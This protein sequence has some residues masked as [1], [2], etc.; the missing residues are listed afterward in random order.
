MRMDPY[1]PPQH[2]LSKIYRTG[3]AIF[4]IGL[5]VF[6]ALGL[7]NRL[8]L[9]TTRGT[10]IAGLSSN[11]LLAWISIVV[12]LALLGA[13]LWGGAVASTTTAVIG[14]LFFLSGLGNLAVL[15]TSW[16]LLAFE[17]PNVVFSLIA[18]LLLMFLGFYG[19]L[20]GGLPEDNPY[21]R[22]RHREPPG[23]LPAQRRSAAPHI[24]GTDPLCEAEIAFAEGHPTP[25]QER[26]VRADAWRHARAAR[27]RAY[28]HYRETHPQD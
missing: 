4:G 12:G 25:Q 18:G 7:A 21:V 17:M 5:I 22:Y 1:L 2:P 10:D 3:A 15:D 16:N 11:G 8:P 23:E 24:D 26:E 14:V 20:S 28:E 9:F 6:G 19:R 13:A 27:H